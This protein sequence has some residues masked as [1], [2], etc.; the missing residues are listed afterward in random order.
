MD[1]HG[2]VP[3][4]PL[5]SGAAPCPCGRP[6]SYDECCG[7][8][9]RGQAPALTA[10]DLMRSRFS[11]F[12]VGE[13]A[14]LLHSWHPDTRPG[15]IRFVPDRRWTRLDVLQAS[16]GPLAS[17]GSVEFEAHFEQGGHHDVLHEHSRFLRHD[18]RWVYLGPLDAPD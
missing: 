16:G 2:A 18:G 1:K 3:T 6:A 4:N 13:S 11:A 15:Y 12:A 7:R 10:E 14:Y 9:H 5:P 8:L 17:E